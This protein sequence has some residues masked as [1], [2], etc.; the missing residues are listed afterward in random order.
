LISSFSLKKESAIV[1]TVPAIT[2][3]SAAIIIFSSLRK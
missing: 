3:A 1:L 2:G